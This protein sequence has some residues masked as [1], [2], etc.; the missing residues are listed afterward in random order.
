[1][2]SVKLPSNPIMKKPIP[3]QKSSNDRFGG[4]KPFEFHFVPDEMKE[5][6]WVG[7]GPARNQDVEP[8]NCMVSKPVVQE[9]IK[10]PDVWDPP[11][12]RF[13]R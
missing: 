3:V 2:P 9:L 5:N 7:Q 12:P 13:M 10:D 6:G 4:L 8:I 1:M 11:S